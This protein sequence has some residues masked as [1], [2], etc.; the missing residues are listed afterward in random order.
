[1]LV[2]N[3]VSSHSTQN[4][5]LLRY[6][7]PCPLKKLTGIDCPGCGFQ[8]SVIA[9][10]HGDVMQS[11]AYYPATFLLLSILIYVMLNSKFQFTNYHRVKKWLLITSALVIISSYLIKITN[12]YIM[13]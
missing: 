4:E 10:L 13:H 1:M 11:I 8:R 5:W 2:D 3:I 7:I 12:T 9:L 6:L